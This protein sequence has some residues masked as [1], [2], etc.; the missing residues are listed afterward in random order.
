MH[1]FRLLQGLND[2]GLRPRSVFKN[3]PLCFF[4]SLQEEGRRGLRASWFSL[5]L[6]RKFLVSCPVPHR[7]QR[8]SRGESQTL[9]LPE[10]T[11]LPRGPCASPHPRLPAGGAGSPLS[12]RPGLTIPHPVGAPPEKEES[13]PGVRQ[14]LSRRAPSSPPS[15]PRPRR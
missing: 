10:T 9:S 13:L 8:Q 15:P 2:I 1:L 5:L 6:V 12:P 14:D 7:G 3:G 4:S 11:V